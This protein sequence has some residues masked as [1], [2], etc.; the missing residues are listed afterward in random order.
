[1][2][3]DNATISCRDGDLIASREQPGRTRTAQLFNDGLM[4]TR[5]LSELLESK[6][7]AAQRPITGG[8]RMALKIVGAGP[9]RTGTASLKV[10][11]EMLGLGR[12]YH[13]GEVMKDISTMDH[14]I[15]AAKGAPDWERVFDG[16]AA[17]VDYPTAK[18]W[19]E[20][21]EY[22][23]EAKIVLS[24][25]DPNTWFDSVHETIFSPR[26]RE[27]VSKGPFAEFSRL[28]VHGD[29]G[30]RIDDRA[31]MADYFEKHV[32]AVKAAI[33]AERLLVYEVKQGWGPLCEFL[34]VR[35]PDEPFPH[36]NSRAETR[37]IVEAMLA[38]SGDLQAELR[39]RSKELFE[40]GR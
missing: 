39:E 6:S 21:A 29:L 16:Y 34:G 14:W 8:F 18:F 15:A 7:L 9:G 2:L 30:D 35:E 20:L 4:V 27:W 32:G 28:A 26:L 3:V 11:L 33:P 5:L 17:A 37:A 10:A 40:P 24:V 38:S 31:F 13:M 23:P 22:Y 12:C 25:R 1:V 19:R 36:V